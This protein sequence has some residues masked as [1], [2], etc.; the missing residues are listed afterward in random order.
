MPEERKAYPVFTIDFMRMTC[1]ECATKKALW[2]VIRLRRT[3]NS[4]ASRA[5]DDCISQIMHV[6]YPEMKRSES[7]IANKAKAR[8]LRPVSHAKMEVLFMS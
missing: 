6:G 3:F 8:N 5:A 7:S 1:A 2:S 4:A